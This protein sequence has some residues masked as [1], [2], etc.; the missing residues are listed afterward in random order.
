VRP[1]GEAFGEGKCG[2]APM[3]PCSLSPLG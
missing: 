3:R 1:I 2:C